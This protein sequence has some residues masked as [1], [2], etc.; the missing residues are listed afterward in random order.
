MPS[1][2]VTREELEDLIACVMESRCDYFGHSPTET[3]SRLPDLHLKLENALELWINGATVELPIPEHFRK[4]G[5]SKW[6][7]EYPPHGEWN[8][9]D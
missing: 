4:L 5:V 8:K 1:L 7:K 9:N 6:E 2:E 3:L